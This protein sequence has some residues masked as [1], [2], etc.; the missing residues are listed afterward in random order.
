MHVPHSNTVRDGDSACDRM[1]RFLKIG[2]S[3]GTAKPQKSELGCQLLRN[4]GGIARIGRSFCPGVCFEVIPKQTITSLFRRLGPGVAGKH[5]PNVGPL[6]IDT[7]VRGSK[8]LDVPSWSLA[9]CGRLASTHLLS[10]Q[11]L[12]DLS[13]QWPM[14]SRL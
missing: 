14:S 3:A 1:R 12:G 13:I 8:L 2:S 6:D 7:L 10:Q 4:K 9:L 5:E 11:H